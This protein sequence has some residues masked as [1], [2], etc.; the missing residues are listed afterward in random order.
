[1]KNIYGLTLQD[2]ENYFLE[3]GS[4]KF[5][6]EQLFRWLYE[7]R[8]ES[9]EEVTNIKKEIIDIIQDIPRLIPYQYNKTLG[10]LELTDKNIALIEMTAARNALYKSVQDAQ[11]KVA[12]VIA[13]RDNDIEV[14]HKEL[15][16]LLA[17]Q[18]NLL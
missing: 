16:K 15:V 13:Q 17:F 9:F 5:H 8:I 3:I 12:E 4:K 6:A 11:M 10:V 7:K 14:Y 2:L 1:M 18:D